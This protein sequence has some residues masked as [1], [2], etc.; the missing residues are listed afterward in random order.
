ME[1]MTRKNILLP[2]EKKYIYHQ[3][4]PIALFEDSLN[5][6][7]PFCQLFQLTETNPT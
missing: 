7:F 4:S 6:F 1:L 5:I 3:P 2:V